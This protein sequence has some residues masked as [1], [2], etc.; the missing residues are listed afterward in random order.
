M[1]NPIKQSPLQ[2]DSAS[3]PLFFTHWLERFFFLSVSIVWPLKLVVNGMLSTSQAGLF[4]FILFSMFRASPVLYAYLVKYISRQKIL[5]CGIVVE[6]CAFLSMVFTQDPT[7][8][9]MLA[10]MAG[11]GGGATSSMLLS[12]LEEVDK[13]K[14]TQDVG[15]SYHQVF[16]IHLLLINLAAVIAPMLA[17]LS[18]EHYIVS[19]ILV[20]VMF[21][22]TA[23]YTYRFTSAIHFLYEVKKRKELAVDSKF[24]FEW[25]ATLAVW[26]GCSVVYAILPSLDDHFLG[27]EGFN[28]WLSL[29]AII[30]T[31]LFFVMNKYGLFRHNT[32]FNALKGLSALLIALFIFYSG[33][34]S[35]PLL[36]TAIVLLSF[37]GYVAFGQLYGL[38]MDTEFKLRK[39][40]YLSLLSLAGAIGEGGVQALFW[41]TGSTQHTLFIVLVF[42]VI[43][44]C[45]IMYTALRKG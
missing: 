37:G 20:F 9:M 14:A 28:F 44:M 31:I 41:L 43:G 26:A 13:R 22:I 19:I 45:P 15:K 34:H 4:Y 10:T 30:V 39:T 24:L 18:Y 29:D 3:V 16:N 11:I 25:L 38:A 5:F 27:T 12:F 8:I 42:V 1:D 17:M 36:V 2:I 23:L 35:F 32:P 33:T 21:I 7:V 40:F 6:S